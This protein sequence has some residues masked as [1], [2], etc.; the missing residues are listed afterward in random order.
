VLWVVK[1]YGCLGT[2]RFFSDRRKVKDLTGNFKVPTL[3]PD[4]GTIVDGSDNIVAWA[5]ANVA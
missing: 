3:I 4:D 2:D 1:T 5:A